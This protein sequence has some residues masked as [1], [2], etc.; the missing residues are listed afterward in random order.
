MRVHFNIAD[1]F[2]CVA[3]AVPQRRAV[4][5]GDVRLR[6]EELD[7]RATRLAHV[8][9]DAGAAPGK[10]VALYLGNTA[11]HATAVL[12]CYKM[13]AVPVNVNYRYVDD[14]L[15]YLLADS[16]AIMVVHDAPVRDRIHRAGAHRIDGNRVRTACALD[17]GLLQRDVR[18]G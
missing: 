3:D 9:A 4:V 8:L 6:Y 13:R 17:A 1:L 18:N 7:D 5:W 16:D 15:S 10:H 12:A 14:E 2:E 11:D